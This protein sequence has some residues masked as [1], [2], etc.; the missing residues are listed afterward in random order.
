[1]RNRTSSAAIDAGAENARNSRGENRGFFQNLPPPDGP[2]RPET[3]AG[4]LPAAC[5]LARGNGM[6]VDDDA[7]CR[8]R[9]PDTAAPP[10][11]GTKAV[12]PGYRLRYSTGR[13]D[14]E[15]KT[16]ARTP[17]ISKSADGNE[18]GLAVAAKSN[19]AG[20]RPRE[21]ELPTVKSRQ[22]RIHSAPGRLWLVTSCSAS[23]NPA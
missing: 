3:A 8:R 6:I 7:P 16:T 11:V 4:P 5:A 17:S 19:H 10:A 14:E 9:W 12:P 22:R 2:R 13:E 1:M 20:Q 18:P 21:R 15:E 23:F